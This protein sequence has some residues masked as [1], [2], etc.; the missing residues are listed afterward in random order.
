MARLTGTNRNDDIDGTRRD[1]VIRGLRGNDEIDGRGGNERLYGQ[2]GNDEL[3]GDGGKDRLFGNKGD[4]E[5]DGGAGN[6]RLSGG[7]G[8]D[9]LDGGAGN[10]RLWGGAGADVFEFE[11]RDGADVIKDLEDGT[12]R[13]EFD[14]FDFA[15]AA[16][17]LSFADQVGDDVVFDFGDDGRLTLANIDLA[18]LGGRDFIL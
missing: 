16:E 5:L 2:A 7:A 13:I 18:D 14:D 9:H 11:R 1:D 15:N 17:A 10:D 8:R 3:D 4:D 6:D 12:D